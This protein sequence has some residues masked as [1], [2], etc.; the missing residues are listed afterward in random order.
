MINRKALPAS[1]L[2]FSLFIQAQSSLQAQAVKEENRPIKTYPF[3]DPNPIPS[4]AV[5]NNI[6]RFYPYFMYDGY[7]NKD[8]IQRWKVVSLDNKY[9]TV[10]VLPEV[11]GKVYGAVEKSTGKDFVYLN[12]VM[13]FRAIG[14]R[15]PWTSGG[16]EHNFGLDIGHAP[17]A[18]GP[19]DY[20]I[21]KTK[22]GNLECIVGGLDLA[23][24][25]Q[26]RVNISLPENSAFF[27]TKAIWYNPTPYHHSYLSWENAA[28]RASD[29]LEF[30]F[31]GNHH[32]DHDGSA[33]PWPIDENGRDLSKY[34][35][36]NFGTS[37]SYHVMGSTRNWFGGLWQ[38]DSIGFGHWAPYTDAPGKKLWIWSLARDG[39][40]WED[41]LTDEDGQYIEA[42]SGVKYNQA[43]VV[44]GY[45][46]PFKQLYLKP[47]YTETKYEAWFPVKGIRGMDDATA[48]GT[49]HVTRNNNRLDVNISPNT[50]LTD[51]LYVIADGKTVFAEAVQLRVLV[52]LSRTYTI[53]TSTKKIEVKTVRGKLHYSNIPEYI[54]RP[55][56]SPEDYQ[57]DDAQRFFLL[58]EDKNSMRLHKEALEIYK[59]C[60]QKEPS[61]TGA[62]TRVAELLFRKTELDSAA[63]YAKKA[64]AIDAYFPAANYILGI[65]ERS[66]GNFNDAE[67]VFSVAVRSMEF[68]S[69]AYR[70]LAAI[71]MLRKDFAQAVQLSHESLKYNSYNIPAIQTLCSALRLSGNTSTAAKWCRDLLDL[72]PLNHH[73]AFELYLL[74]QGNTT[75]DAFKGLIRNEFPHESYLELACAYYYNGCINEAKK[76][77]QLAPQQPMILYWLAYMQSGSSHAQ[78]LL[79]KADDMN[80]NFVFPSREESIP[81]LQHA[82]KSSGSWKPKY[83]LALIYWHKG[84]TASALKLL[85]D[86]GDEP[87]FAPFYI[88]R[89]SLSTTGASKEHDLRRALQIAP[90]EWRTHQYMADHL[91]DIGKFQEAANIWALAAKKF[92]DNVIVRL[93][94]AKALLH[95]GQYA[96]CLSVLNNVVVMPQEHA[97]QGHNIYE[98]ANIAMALEKIKSNNWDSAIAY[99]DSAKKWPEHL[100]SGEPYDP[101]NRLSDVLL[102]HC[103]KQQQNTRMAAQLKQG[104]IDYTIRMWPNTMKPLSNFIGLKEL[105]TSASRSQIDQMMNDW[106]QQV[107]SLQ[108]WGLPG[109]NSST[110][111]DFVIAAIT[112]SPAAN[113]LNEKL[114]TNVQDLVSRQTLEAIRIVYKD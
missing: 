74:K 112:K 42:Q 51:S 97:N 43:D 34:R 14:S 114:L 39:A 28:F 81:V 12:R 99:L 77:L 41:L 104:I 57:N 45:H 11:G 106:K 52:P 36:N 63:H 3:S 40:I 55:V 75:L 88:S 102:A 89:A 22:N 26:W 6:S 76:V 83:F 29:D 58:A 108:R 37:K 10:T 48:A 101:D 80:A 9:I 91:F 79:K 50:N 82:I 78:T 23:S 93:G 17:W 62:L 53:P 66:R 107:D 96:S 60:L 94:Y 65:I 100:G 56:V 67:E 70:Q 33:R 95:A 2:A 98:S 35:N 110:A 13:K 44:S 25:T 105:Q 61:H 18:A 54:Q 103:Y 19:V 92:P 87:D 31:P 90:H 15:G 64:L 59:Q 8:T 68:R 7:T 30:F 85:N 86:C 73:A 46:S 21:R 84:A 4:M 71:S 72:D 38:N 47:G 24:R 69:E 16:I 5:N 27:E 32:I 20:V 109:G 1:V 111:R 49:L 113:Q